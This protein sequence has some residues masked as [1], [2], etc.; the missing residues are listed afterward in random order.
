MRT[1]HFLFWELIVQQGEKH[2]SNSYSNLIRTAIKTYRFYR[3]RR[4]WLTFQGRHPG[5]SYV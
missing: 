1:C 3:N 2:V 4:R 5:R